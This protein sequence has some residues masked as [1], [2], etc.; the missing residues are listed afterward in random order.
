MNIWRMKKKALTG[1]E[2]ALGS[3]VLQQLRIKSA[4]TDGSQFRPK[5]MEQPSRASILKLLQIE[6]GGF[7]PEYGAASTRA[8]VGVGINRGLEM[9]LRQIHFKHQR[10]MQAVTTD[11]QWNKLEDIRRKLSQAIDSWFKRL[12]DFMPADAVNGLSLM[13]SGPEETKL[14]LPSDFPRCDHAKL[15]ILSHAL[16]ERELRIGQAHDALKKLR[17]LLGLKSFLVRRKRQ[18]VGYTV[19]TRAESEIQKVDVHVKRW[20]KVYRRAWEAVEVLRGDGRIPQEYRAWLELRPLTNGD[21]I[22]LSDWMSD[23]AYWKKVGEKEAAEA[24]MRGKGPKKLS[25]IWKIELDLTVESG[26]GIEDA[27]EGWTNEGNFT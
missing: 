12:G 18:N 2:E 7:G 4:L 23:Q 27:V 16:I 17:T 10:D 15:G 25:W 5:M 13:Q 20:Q 8:N 3:E 24:T 6:E 9:E 22:M 19:T 1:L 14:G 11:V 26:Q 21:C